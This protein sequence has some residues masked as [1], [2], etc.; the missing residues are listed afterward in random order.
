MRQ[1]LINRR[2]G[3]TLIELLV[4]IAIIAVLIGLLLPAVQ[5]VREAANNMKCKAN[6]GQVG[7]ASINAAEQ[8]KG[9]LPPM[10]GLRY[11]VLQVTSGGT[12]PSGYSVLYHILPYL[13]RQDVHDQGDNGAQ[14]PIALY[15]CPSDPTASSATNTASTGSSGS[16][17]VLAAYCNTAA[18]LL[19]FGY[20]RGSSS[21]A[22]I[23]HGGGSVRY[24][25]AIR[26]GT[27]QTIFFTEKYADCD[28]TTN[29]WA[30]ASAT[31]P[32]FGVVYTG[33]ND[34]FL[35]DPT[36]VPQ[37]SP[38]L[39]TCI[40][41]APQSGHQAGVNVC[42]GDRSVRTINYSVSQATWNAATTPVSFAYNGRNPLSLSRQDLVGADFDQ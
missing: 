41:N 25:D 15:L 33:T 34:D 36:L 13:E 8:H 28:G 14:I 27:S 3:F 16:G 5:K 9:I 10:F 35:F 39:G 31:S 12:Q 18:N 38:A 22:P 1:R 40:P 21:G 19:V 11:P 17:S 37:K 32:H 20:P 42:M 23:W 4:V 26:D 24:P 7:L 29:I 30:F 2:G 6:L